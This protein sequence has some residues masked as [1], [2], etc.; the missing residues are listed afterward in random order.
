MPQFQ[1]VDWGPSTAAQAAE[2]FGTSF[3]ESLKKAREQQQQNDMLQQILRPQQAQ[4]NN[5]PLNTPNAMQGPSYLGQEN[6]P[7]DNI[8][9]ALTNVNN[10]PDVLAKQG[11]VSG[12]NPEGTSTQR[13]S[14]EKRAQIRML[15][16]ELDK[17][18]QPIYETQT[19]REKEGIKGDVK[20]STEFLSGIDKMRDNIPRK[21]QAL[22]QI[23][24]AIANGSN[25]DTFR[26]QLS[27]ITGLESLRSATGATLRSGTKEFFISDLNSIPGIRFNQ[28]LEKALSSAMTDDTRTKEANEML[29]AGMRVNLDLDKVRAALTSQIESQYRNQFRYIPASISS[30]VNK[31]LLPHA[32]QLYDQWANEVQHIQ[33]N[34]DSK[35]QNFSNVLKNPNSSPRQRKNAA[36]K[37]KLKQAIPGSELN[38]T[39][40]MI[41]LEKYGDDESKAMEAAKKLGYKIPGNQ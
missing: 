8:T 5:N 26:N 24:Y 21:E 32:Q 15:S 25:L 23:D 36:D 6:Q 31:A 2:N 37:V 35:I 11:I 10:H 12:Q 20:R 13:I 30:D 41:L 38:D 18:L 29:A 9:P 33:E 3:S 34:H 1:V 39:M 17:A 22:R 19:L 27:D 28:F 4:Q 16:P 14:P 40:G 7:P